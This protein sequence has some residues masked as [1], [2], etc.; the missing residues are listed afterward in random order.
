MILSIILW[1]CIS[2]FSLGMKDFKL[3]TLGMI[4]ILLF[5]NASNEMD[6]MF[7]I[8]SLS[9]PLIILSLFITLLIFIYSLNKK[10]MIK[11]M[12]VCNLVI[13]LFF[14]FSHVFNFFL[15]FELSLLPMFVMI[16]GMGYQPERFKA[17]WYMM[18]YT[19]LASAPLFVNVCFIMAFDGNCYIFLWEISP[20]EED[21]VLIVFSSTLALFVKIPMFLTHS[22]LPKAHVEAPLESS[23]ILASLMLKMGVLG[24][25][26]T[27]HLFNFDTYSTIVL[28]SLSLMGSFLASLLALSSDDMK[29]S[30][31]YSSVSHMNFMLSGLMTLKLLSINASLITMISHGLS[32]TALF[33]LVTIIYNKTNSRSILISKGIMVIYPFMNLLAFVAWCLNLAAPPSMAFWGEVWSFSCLLSFSW[34]SFFFSLV[35][36]LVNSFF[37]IF[38]YNLEFH[39]SCKVKS[40]SF[41]DTKCMLVLMMVLIPS[42]LMFFSMAMILY[43]DSLI[44]PLD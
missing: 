43:E 27:F 3:I 35:Y 2:T 9:Y 42:V 5:L 31:A 39:C 1:F 33:I 34:I 6:L 44:K 41:V 13:V 16:L 29:M 32:S 11:L 23:I 40:K 26:R 28:I 8:D 25:I 24:L 10:Y 15:M 12:L 17:T 38:N 20:V 14:S 19:L 30:V 4:M 36:I 21:S 18:M 22:W 37:S 7:F